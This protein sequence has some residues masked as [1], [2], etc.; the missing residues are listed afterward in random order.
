MTLRLLTAQRR[1]RGPRG[2]ALGRPGSPRFMVACAA[3]RRLPARARAAGGRTWSTAVL[4][5]FAPIRLLDAVVPVHGRLPAALA[6]P[7]RA[8]ARPPARRDRDEPRAPAPRAARVARR[9]LGR[10]RVLAGRRGP[11]ARHGL[12][13]EGLAGC[14]R[15]PRPAPR[16]SLAA[17]GVA[18]GARRP[19]ART[20]RCGAG[21]VGAI[22]AVRRSRSPSGCPRVRWRPAGPGGRARRRMLLAFHAPAPAAAPPPRARVAAPRLAGLRVPR[23]LPGRSTRASA[24]AAR[25]VVDLRLPRRGAADPGAARRQPV[26]GG[27]ARDEPQRGRRWDRRATRQRYRGRVTRLDGTSCCA[28]TS[29]AAD[30]HALRARPRPAA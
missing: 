30:G 6:R 25:A 20:A 27:G 4:D 28:P 9:A 2:R 1:A 21:A 11:R 14:S 19:R 13:R 8:R 18:A 22:A 3:P 7:R 12:R 24:A 15:S 23:R 10:L 5:T 29:R 16:R 26:A 17:V